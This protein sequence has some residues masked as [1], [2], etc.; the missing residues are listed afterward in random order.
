MKFK[1]TSWPPTVQ[2]ITALLQYTLRLSKNRFWLSIGAL[3]LGLA[4]EG[5]SIFLLLPLFSYLASQKVVYNAELAIAAPEGLGDW[6]V[7][8]FLHEILIYFFLIVTAAGVLNRG[9]TLFVAT[10]VLD[11]S[12]QLR[13]DLFDAI[14]KARWSFIS[15]HRKADLDHLLNGDIDRMQNSLTSVFSAIQNCTAVA[16][17][18]VI[19]LVVSPSVTA[20]AFLS[21]LLTL[22]LSSRMRR[23]SMSYGE[24]YSFLR[25][26][27]YRI[28]SDYLS[29]M[30]LNK[31]LSSESYFINL[32]T[33]SFEK[34]MKN[35][36]AFSSQTSLSNLTL[37]TINLII[38]CIVLYVSVIFANLDISQIIVLFVVFLRINP[39]FNSLQ[40]NM[41]QL[42]SD[43][44]AFMQMKRLLD[45]CRENR[46]PEATEVGVWSETIEVAL[47]IQNVTYSVEHVK[48]IDDVSIEVR[49]GEITVLAGRSGS[50]KTTL[51]DIA[52]GLLETDSGH[53]SVDG[54][55]LTPEL[56]VSWRKQVAYV[57]QQSFVL[58]G[59]I[60]ENLLFGDNSFTDEQLVWA[61]N[62]SGAQSIVEKL[63]LGLETLVGDG[64]VN[65]SGGEVQRLSL[66]RALLRKP[67]L[68]ILDEVTSGL[69]SV[70][71][72]LIL[73]SLAS[74]TKW[75]TILMISHDEEVIR[76]ARNLIEL[77][78][79]R[80]RR[81]SY[82]VS[83]Q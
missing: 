13:T 26:Q 27:Q 50:G 23:W 64:G 40:L 37:Q 30:K 52:M 16:I 63:P 60:R 10:V 49:G 41:Q 79:G 11:T 68:L 3:T 57:P 82:A 48:I 51:A 1:L 55:I 36:V 54:R 19:S 69:D 9:K 56:L 38:V 7:N 42:L 75:V 35:V 15:R 14:S 47:R 25:Q 72:D 22:A 53:V 74:L 29:G 44:P 45:A 70:N 73:D 59:S 2:A 58:A 28:I 31:S 78:S 67:K 43:A 21:G 5:A 62:L 81:V 12:N 34:G 61:L 24:E 83:D 17:Y 65:I 8:L 46:E 77:E 33:K 32:A 66:A 80:V 76:R 39:R 20:L 71:R 6:T 4:L 18:T